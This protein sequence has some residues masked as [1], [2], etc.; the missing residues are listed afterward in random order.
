MFEHRLGP[1]ST[2]GNVTMELHVQQ[3]SRQRWP[4]LLSCC[5]CCWCCWRWWW[6]RRWL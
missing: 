3:S 6:R 2:Q 4:V 5:C 1:V